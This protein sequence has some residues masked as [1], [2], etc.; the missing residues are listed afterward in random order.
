MAE[1]AGQTRA[2]AVLREYLATRD[3]TC[4]SC[5]Y[6]LRG[7]TDVFC[8]ECGK[9]IPRPPAEYIA[10]SQADLAALKLACWD[11]G[12]VVTGV[13]AERC[14][15]CGG[16]AMQRFRGDKPPARYRVPFLPR[17]LPLL[18]TAN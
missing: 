12:Y 7:A 5:G 6:N 2:A 11:C 13:N 3:I 14:P 4:D 1:G 9:V 8:P 17:N 15:E 16:R 18:L 10:R